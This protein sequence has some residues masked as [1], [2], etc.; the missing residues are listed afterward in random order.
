LLYTFKQFIGGLSAPL[1]FAFLVVAIGLALRFMRR[2]RAAMCCFVCAAV[3]AYAGSTA[4]IAGLL[5]RP[6]EQAY[7]PLDPKAPLPSVKFI[8]VL[9]ADYTPSE[10]VP[11][12]AQLGRESLLRAAEGIRLARQLPD[13]RLVVSGGAP[14]PSYAPARGYQQL[15]LALGVPDESIIVLDQAVDTAGEAREVAA[16]VRREPFLL[17][18]AAYHMPRAMRLITAAGVTPIPAPTGQF[19]QVDD[20]LQWKD[21]LPRSG[22]L[23]IT[24]ASLHE[25]LGLAAI[26]L[27]LGQP[28]DQVAP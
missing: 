25:Y 19:I 1:T 12:T 9:G 27:G 11:I 3:I 6:L 4:I 20:G 16:Y 14:S 23:R 17:V 21:L 2:Q 13:A 15:A 5:L 22:A 28:A 26:A 10:F 24:E 7:P 8:V 18:T